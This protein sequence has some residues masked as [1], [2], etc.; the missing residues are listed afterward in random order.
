[1]VARAPQLVLAGAGS[2]KTETLARRAIDLILRH[3]ERP[4]RLLCITFTNRAAAEM[5]AR[6]DWAPGHPP[7]SAPSMPAWRVS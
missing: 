4:D 2:G 6:M 5:R 1:V 3:D 7:G